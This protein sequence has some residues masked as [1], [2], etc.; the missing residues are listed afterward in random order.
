GPAN[1]APPTDGGGMVTIQTTGAGTLQK[2]SARSKIDVAGD[3]TA[4][5]IRI[6]AGGTV[7]IDGKLLA[8]GISGSASAGTIMI[9]AGG[10]VITHFDALISAA[11]TTLGVNG[12]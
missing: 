9:D 8:D 2:A 6:F 5:A 1:R 12:A 4:G 3:R 10:D 11:G 7:T